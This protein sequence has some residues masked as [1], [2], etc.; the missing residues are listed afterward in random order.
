MRLS[1]MLAGRMS[2]TLL[3]ENMADTGGLGVGGVT[4]CWTAAPII[5]ARRGGV[6]GRDPSRRDEKRTRVRRGYP[7][8]ME[9]FLEISG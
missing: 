9:L 5:P 8:T 7:S 6:R 3:L 1:S 2:L 4:P